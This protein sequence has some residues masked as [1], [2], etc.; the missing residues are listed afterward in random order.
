MVPHKIYQIYYLDYLSYS[1][2]SEQ[3]IKTKKKK[4]RLFN[5]YK[6]QVKL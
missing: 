6:M 5:Q 3:K 2:K 1:L 4:T